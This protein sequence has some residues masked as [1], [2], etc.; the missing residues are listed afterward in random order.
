MKEKRK[1]KYNTV[2]ELLKDLEQ[3]IDFLAYHFNING[4]EKED[5]K[6]ELYLLIVQIWNK[7]NNKD[8][9]L[10]FW[11]LRCKW[12]LLNLVNKNMREPLNNSISLEKFLSESDTIE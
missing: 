9:G 11:F 7:H 1:I 2:E 8:K 4:Y 3:A 6:Q 10:G 5:L 12:H